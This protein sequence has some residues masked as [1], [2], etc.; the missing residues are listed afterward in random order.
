MISALALLL[1][2]F[3]AQA[4][5]NDVIVIG[6]GVSGLVAAKQLS[7]AGYDV[8][9]L[10]ARSRIGGRVWTDARFG[11][12]VEMGAQWIYVSL[13]CSMQPKMASPPTFLRM[14]GIGGGNPIYTL[15][16]DAGFQ[17]LTTSPQS[18]RVFDDAGSAI[19]A[20]TEARLATLW[21]HITAA[22]NAGYNAASDVDLRTTVSTNIGY[23]SMNATDKLLVDY[24]M[25]SE[26]HCLLCHTP[27]H[28]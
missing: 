25:S 4:L 7:R 1:S 14:K 20:A 11:S 10:E 13:G 18:S 19:S 21:S 16:T 8:L 6:A 9:I 12:P 5:E 15:A 22:V 26:A 24:L 2:A 3:T 27:A 23:N 17:T 28:K